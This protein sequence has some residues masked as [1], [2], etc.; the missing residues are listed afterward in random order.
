MASRIDA[1]VRLAKERSVLMRKDIEELATQIFFAGESAAARM[2]MTKMR[3]SAK[4]YQAAC[5]YV[6]R[7]IGGY[8]EGIDAAL[9]DLADSFLFDDPKLHAMNSGEIPSHLNQWASLK[10]VRG[11]IL[12]ELQLSA[13]ARGEKVTT[14]LVSYAGLIELAPAAIREV[15]DFPLS[16][17]ECEDIIDHLKSIADECNKPIP[18]DRRLRR[19]ANRVWNDLESVKHAAISAGAATPAMT[20]VVSLLALIG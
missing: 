9:E 20:A 5:L 19:I 17:D 8:N 18:D 11:K 15:E 14:F 6:I 4:H 16:D 3:I 10:T 7:R 1:A 2:Q 13:V 12:A